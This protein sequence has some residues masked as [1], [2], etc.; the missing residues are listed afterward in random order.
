MYLRSRNQN[1]P[2]EIS[3]KSPVVYRLALLVW[4]FYELEMIIFAVE[5]GWLQPCQKRVRQTEEPLLG[6]MLAFRI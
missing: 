3:C 5:N 6:H 1:D 4:I 2:S